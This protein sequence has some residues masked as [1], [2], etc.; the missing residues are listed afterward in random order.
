M[1]LM[2]NLAKIL[3]SAVLGEAGAH[4]FEVAC[5]RHVNVGFLDI[6]GLVTLEQIAAVASVSNGL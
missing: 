2:P 4:L 6:E 1:P 5:L 3:L